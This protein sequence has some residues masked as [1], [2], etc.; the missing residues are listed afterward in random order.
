MVQISNYVDDVNS[1]QGDLSGIAGTTGTIDTVLDVALDVLEL[2]GEIEDLLRERADAIDL[3]NSV[4]N[5]L[6]AAPFGI[7]TAIT[8]LNNIANTVSG[9]VDDQADVMGV[10]DDAWAPTR[11]VVDNMSTF[12]GTV[13]T[14]VQ[15]L[16]TLN[17]DRVTEA[18]L[19]VDSLGDQEIYS[20]SELASRM[21][22]YSDIAD[23]WITT[24]DALMAPV[25]AAI[26]AIQGTVDD[27]D[28]LVPSLSSITSTLNSALAVF[29]AAADIAN[30]IKNAL[31]VDIYIPPF[32]PTIN[33]LDII[34]T[35][36]DLGSL[37]LGIVEDFV[38]D[39][40]AALGIN[41]NAVFDT[42]ASQMTAIMDP[43]FDVLDDIQ[44]AATALL[45]DVAGAVGDL[46]T[47]LDNLL[48]GA[49]SVAQ[50]AAL[51][52][53]IIVGDA[54]DTTTV[55][56]DITGTTT[57]DAIFGLNSNDTLNGG[58]GND[59]LFGGADGDV[60]IGGGGNDE[61]FGGTGE[62]F[63]IG[64]AGN[65]YYDG[66]ADNDVLLAQ[67]GDD[68]LNGS[69]GQDIQIGGD[70]ADTFVFLQGNEVDIVL[71]FE[72]NIDMIGVDESFGYNNASSFVADNAITF[73]DITILSVGDDR[74]IL[75]GVNNA[76]NLVD[77]IVFV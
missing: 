54:G 15:G 69:S 26:S 44:S 27:I 4:V 32:G 45:G 25:N 77:D 46:Q 3:P 61:M 38:I 10:L 74:M 22:D 42:I 47:A 16:L 21:Q 40:L 2:P 56:D 39:V 52:E 17:S 59:F 72:N 41:I 73:G 67:A 24:R 23:S 60:L 49:T 29:D 70:G 9:T 1:V 34:E 11:N 7:G 33:I 75:L 43:I 58:G 37:I 28:A 13:N 8:Q 36:A 14:S 76:N 35:V 12:L 53:N 64:I 57:E 65:N 68:V 18:D 51:F 20:G 48:A 6:G 62:D 30:S 19:L 31:D 71:D 50:E 63:I 66:G 55:A 5:L